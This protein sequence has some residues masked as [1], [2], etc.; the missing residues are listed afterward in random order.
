MIRLVENEKTEF[1]SIVNNKLEKEIVA[2]LNSKTGGDIY[3]GIAD[4]G[5]VLEERS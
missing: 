1:K 5:S 3:I 4:D 2:F